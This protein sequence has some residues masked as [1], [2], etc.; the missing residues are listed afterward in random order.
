M[1][2]W[3]RKFSRSAGVL[4]DHMENIKIKITDWMQGLIKVFVTHYI[5]IGSRWRRVFINHK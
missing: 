1:K 4:V 5:R 2:S 3:N